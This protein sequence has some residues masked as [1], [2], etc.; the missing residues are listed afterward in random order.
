[1]M[2]PR[3]H[4]R[5]GLWARSIEG[6]AREAGRGQ[7]HT[8]RVVAE[9]TTL[10]DRLT[11]GTAILIY[12]ALVKL[13]IHLLTNGGY[14]YHR[15]E[16]YYIACGDHL[17]WGYIDH[18]PL[19]P[20]L[21]RI[22]TAT[23]GSSLAALRLIPAIAGA[24]TVFIAGKT[25]KVLSGRLFAQ[26]LTAVAVLVGGTYLFYGT[27]LTTNVFDQ[28]L[29]AVTLYLFVSILKSDNRRLWIWL[30]VAVGIGLLNKHTM[31]F[32]AGSLFAGLLLTDERRRLTSRWPW[33]AAGIAAV[34]FLPN[35][36]WE[37]AHG[38][39]TIEFLQK[40][41]LNRMSAVSPGIFFL[42]QLFGLNPLLL[43][44]WIVGLWFAL[45]SK[46]GKKMR[47]IGWAFALLY[48]YFVLSR[49]KEY[50]LIPFYPPLL[51]L[52]AV[53]VE[54]FF[55]SRKLRWA[56]ATAMALLVVGAALLAPLSLPILSP[57]RLIEY[58][59]VVDPTMK[60]LM[61]GESE[62]LPAFQDMFGWE[63]MVQE[64]ARIYH[65]L[66]EE[67]RSVA[68]I[69]GNNY[70]QSAAI[71]FFGPKYGIPKAICTHNNYWYWGPRDYTGEVLITIGVRPQA[72]QSAF[73]T[74]ALATTITHDY[75]VWYETNQPVFIWRDMKM[76]L[77]VAWPRMK[78]F[79]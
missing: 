71:D 55:K 56:P 68:A 22:I 78:L 39:P 69:S 60:H 70:G 28:L 50:Y 6:M 23:L 7:R 59:R 48:V 14:G 5:A 33:Y 18:P 26:A 8:E 17:A 2:E 51:A 54:R 49:A 30:G 34:I 10:R 45:L 53:E 72:L 15:D 46:G 32:L 12:I 43:P 36:I 47:S 31:A 73:G 75:V 44:V 4:T 63:E 42:G 77:D 66:P 3:V 57:E 67:M 61:P 52:G 74:V 25:A 27:L 29:W 24:L 11:S 35:V 62:M 40:A 9:Q 64:V 79:Y 1:M 37:I 76:P 21:A 13:A 19:T 16:L 38:W 58:R 41:E 65:S 20:F